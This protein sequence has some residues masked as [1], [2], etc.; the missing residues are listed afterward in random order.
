MIISKKYAQK[1]IREGKAIIVNRT[2]DQKIWI[3]RDYGKTYIVI[4]RF[5]KQRIDHHIE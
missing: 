5:D 2:T 4:N 1:L 3:E